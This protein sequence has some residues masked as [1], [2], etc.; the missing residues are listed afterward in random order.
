MKKYLSLALVLTLVLMSCGKKTEEE[1]AVVELQGISLSKKSL[2]MEIGDKK[3][4]IVIYNPEEA[5]KFAPAVTW[6]S[7]N[8][9][10]ATVQD[11]KVTAKQKGKTTISAYCGKFSADCEVEVENATVPVTPKLEVSPT[12][13]DDKGQG[14]T[15]TI[16]VTSNR[17]WTAACEQAWATVSPAEGNGDATVTVTVEANMATSADAQTI[18]FT[19]GTVKKTVTVNRPAYHKICPI[20][21]DIKEK[22][23]GVE[24]GSFDVQVTSEADWNVQC[25]NARVHITKTGNGASVTVDINKKELVRKKSVDSISVVFYN[26][27]LTDTLLIRQEVPYANLKPGD[28]ISANG[29]NYTCKL[30]SNIS[31]SIVFEYD[32]YYSAQNYMQANPSSGTGDATV[33]VKIKKVHTDGQEKKGGGSVWIYG[34]DEWAGLK[35]WSGNTD[36][37]WANF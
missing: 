22:E 5:E 13:I 11:G 6:E 4:L 14:G 1:M 31:W 21:L 33:N 15:Y 16:K 28:F 27:D 34:T 10:V 18:T 37:H 32:T 2:S 23:V 19:A 30:E 25:D 12:T 17:A 20:T 7:S 8:E 35:I 26:D 24:G 29:L 3:T 36:Y 9:R